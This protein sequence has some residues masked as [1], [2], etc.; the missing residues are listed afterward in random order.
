MTGMQRKEI[1]SIDELIDYTSSLL[2]HEVSFEPVE[3]VADK[4]TFSIEVHG[5]EWSKLVD[6]RH[7]KYI[8]ALQESINDLLEDNCVK[9][10]DEVSKTI[11]VEINAGSTKMLP[12]ITEIVKTA[13]T[14]MTPEQTFISVVLGILSITGYFAW[15]RWVDFKR[16][17]AALSEH[18][19]TKRTAMEA[20]LAEREAR[21]SELLSYERPIKVLVNNLGDEDTLHLPGSPGIGATKD[22]AKRSLPKIKRSEEKTTYADGEY[23][24]NSIDYSLGEL[25]LHLAQEGHSV[26]AYTSQLS[27]DDAEALFNDISSRQLSEDLPLSL[28]LQI[29]IMHTDKRIKHG[30]IIGT[31][32]IRPDKQHAKLSEILV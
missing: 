28:T 29:N 3:I 30:S 20:I 8:M 24:L 4:I 19:Q 16:E 11:K 22:E 15:K 9:E 23:V 17:E 18:E 32:Q 31:A 26:K 10:I 2:K 7:A 5:E 6:I 13:I 25:I 12:D 21:D 1:K 14:P 27:D